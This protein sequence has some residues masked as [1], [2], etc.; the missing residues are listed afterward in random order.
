MSHNIIHAFLKTLMHHR[1][2]DICLKMVADQ[3]QIDLN[4]VESCGSS[5][6]DLYAFFM[7]TMN[8]LLYNTIPVSDIANCDERDVLLEIMAT[9][10]EILKPYKYFYA[11][12]EEGLLKSADLSA[13]CLGA[14]YQAFMGILSYYHM[15]EGSLLDQLKR[16]GAFSIYLIAIKT[17]IKDES[18]SQDST[19]ETLD[20]LLLKG[21]GLLKRYN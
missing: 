9:R 6:N 2:R 13:L 14:E 4:H 19:I 1:V 5:C 16:H 12:L 21:E 8:T 15:L 10:L 7:N 18:P 17:W 20:G 3:A 11:F